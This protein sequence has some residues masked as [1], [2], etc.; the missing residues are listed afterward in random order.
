MGM[1][2]NDNEKFAKKK[3]KQVQGRGKQ[4]Q[5]N[6]FFNLFFLLFKSHGFAIKVRKLH[7]NFLKLQMLKEAVS[8]DK[9]Y[10]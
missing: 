9:E 1:K 3:M 5:K 7:C 8:T 10:N 6:E 2:S 4:T